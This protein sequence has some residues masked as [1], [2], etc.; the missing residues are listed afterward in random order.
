MQ[1][2][3]TTVLGMKGSGKT[4]LVKFL[5]RK[6]QRILFLDPNLE[7]R[8]G[9]IFRSFQQLLQ[10]HVRAEDPEQRYICRFESDADIADAL[11]FAWSAQG[12]ALVVEE[13]DLLCS[14]QGIEETFSRIIRHGRHRKLDLFAVS[15]RP[16]EISRLLTSQSD[17][18]ISFAQREESDLEYLRKRG[19]DPEK[20]KSLQQFEYLSSQDPNTIHNLKEH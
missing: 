1:N 5:T 3:I 6:R 12:W 4:T 7:Y 8:E 18:I 16:A 11:A 19:F 17:E 9:L 15:R 13:A 10:W 14:P 2:K 20:L